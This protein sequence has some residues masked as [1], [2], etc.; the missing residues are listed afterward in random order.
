MVPALRVGH[1]GLAGTALRWRLEHHNSTAP[2]GQTLARD[3]RHCPVFA[4]NLI[5]QKESPA[6]GGAKS[7]MG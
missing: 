7:G 6:A 3:W 2:T 5:A 4:R 1:G